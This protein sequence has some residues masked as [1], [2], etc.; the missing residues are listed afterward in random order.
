MVLNINIFINL[1][2]KRYK[3]AGKNNGFKQ[4]YQIKA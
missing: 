1:Y 2:F 4:A 3:N